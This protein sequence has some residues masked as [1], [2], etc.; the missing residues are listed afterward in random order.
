MA[1]LLENYAPY[2][3]LTRCAPRQTSIPLERRKQG[4]DSPLDLK[5]LNLPEREEPFV[6][7]R[8]IAHSPAVYIRG[9]YK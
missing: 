5:M 3:V 2:P 6:E 7:I 9:V 1:E 4:F 8:P